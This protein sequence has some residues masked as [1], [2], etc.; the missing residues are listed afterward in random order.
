MWGGGGW[1][2]LCAHQ[3]SPA[4][5]HGT[6]LYTPQRVKIVM[7]MHVACST[8]SCIG[9]MWQ[10]IFVD[11]STF[12]MEVSY[13]SHPSP[14]PWLCGRLNCI[15][16]FITLPHYNASH[17]TYWLAQWEAILH[18]PVKTWDALCYSYKVHLYICSSPPH[19]P[20]A[21]VVTGLTIPDL[22]RA[23]SPAPPE[24]IIIQFWHTYC[25]L[26]GAGLTHQPYWFL[27][28]YVLYSA[29]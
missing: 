10:S 22:V 25:H 26:A 14:S 20:I 4:H 19:P 21:M 24:H 3:Y 6:G 29:D 11:I 23:A 5:R 17:V 9:E 27:Q 15:R 7:V 18:A 12:T 8:K 16:I 2:M 13:R 28:P 1:T